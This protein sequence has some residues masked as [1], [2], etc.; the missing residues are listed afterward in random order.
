MKIIHKQVTLQSTSRLDRIVT[1]R[2][3]G[4]PIFLFLMFLVFEATF[5]LGAYPMGWIESGVDMLSTYLQGVMPHGVLKDL[6]VDGVVGGVGGVIV[7]LPNILIL[8][9][10]IS[11]MEDSGYM[12][13]ASFVMDKVMHRIGLHGRSFIPLVMGF[14]CNVPA[15]M[16]TSS[17]ESR[18]SRLIT[19]FINP[20]MSCSARLTVYILL[21][22]TF[23]PHH[24][25]LVF[26]A[27][28][29]LGILLAVLTSLA[30]RR[31]LFRGRRQSHQ[32]HLKPY[33]MPSLRSS[34][35]LM[36]DK[37]WQYLKKMGGLILVASIVVWFLSYYPRA[38]H[39]S[40]SEQ[41]ENSY[42]GQ[43][44]K[45]CE[46]VMAPLGFQWRA[47][48]S[49]ISGVAAKE[50]IVSTLGVLYSES[51]ARESGLTLP[52]KLASI[53]PQTSR[54]DFTSLSALSF[55]VFVLIYFPCIASLTAI[56]RESGSWRW[57]AASMLYS[58]ILAWVLAFIVYQ[59]GGLFC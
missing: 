3:W 58:T 1:H 25:S 45:F 14:G 8:Y 34:L 55:M 56:A 23:F 28:Y 46:P 33:Q 13:R 38:D 10:L 54:P 29:L 30:L 21:V 37:A 52:Q 48:V 36:W 17:I 41:Q 31:F 16:A 57:A 7:F 42:M 18:S 51:D 27:L 11:I 35:S 44:G 22:G 6:L 20:F 4:V 49:L 59:V 5:S 50:L 9:L 43:I 15:I 39:M 19:I 32:F 12:S 2:V 26:F 53:N 40:V 47:N 24:G